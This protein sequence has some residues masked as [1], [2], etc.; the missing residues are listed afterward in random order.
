[1]AQV[2]GLI[3][4]AEPSLPGATANAATVILAND[5]NNAYCSGS[6]ITGSVDWALIHGANIIN[7]SASH[8]SA[9]AQYLDYRATIT[10][11]PL[12]VASA[13]NAGNSSPVGS[14]LWNGVIV[15]A[16][17]DF[18][19]EDRSD[20]KKVW[21]GSQARN[22]SGGSAGRELPHLV[23]PGVSVRTVD[24]QGGDADV[25]GTSFAAPQVSG[26]GAVIMERAG[27]TVWPEAVTAMLLAGPEQGVAPTWPMSLMDT[28]DDL[29]GVGSVNAWQSSRIGAVHQ[30]PGGAPQLFGH[31]YGFVSNSTVPNGSSMGVWETTV[32]VGTTLRVAVV[33][34]ASVTCSPGDISSCTGRDFVRARLLGAYVTGS[35]PFIVPHIVGDSNNANSNYQYFAWT[36]NTGSSRTVSVGVTINS[37]SG[38]ASTTWGL[39]WTTNP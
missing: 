3:R 23:A 14:D 29:G 28:V 32:P 8:A 33:L 39:A 26:V 34:W 10:P 17:E 19:D 2:A 13:G 6:G 12:V 15:G 16:A 30:N 25:T 7:R 31:D 1:M 11:Y 9:S 27:I 37:W 24:G 35:P 20:L 38:M 5:A 36:N 21:S 22:V 4:N 18:G